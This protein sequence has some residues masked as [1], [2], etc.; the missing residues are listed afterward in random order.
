M[1]GDNFSIASVEIPKYTE[2]LFGKQERT[3]KCDKTI[4]QTSSSLKKKILG[5][6]D[7]VFTDQYDS[8]KPGR[9]HSQYGGRQ[10]V[11]KYKI[12]ILF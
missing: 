12:G 5:P 7:L 1:T 4:V 2:C 8:R 10:K 6:G 3:S 11:S 9:F